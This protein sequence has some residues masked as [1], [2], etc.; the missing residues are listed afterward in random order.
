[1]N[2]SINYEGSFSIDSHGGKLTGS[3]EVRG[4]IPL[5]STIHMTNETAEMLFF[6]LRRQLQV[7]NAAY[8][9]H[10]TTHAGGNMP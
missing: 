6:C 1:M 10:S 4:S 2:N 5:G 7:A 9:V 3:Q 8:Y